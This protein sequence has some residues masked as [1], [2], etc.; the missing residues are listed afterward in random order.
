MATDSI[1]IFTTCASA[2]EAGKIAH[3]LVAKRLVAC[4]NVI[5]GVKSVFW[6]NGKIGEA[7]EVLLVL[8]TRRE[9][10]PAVKREIE[11]IHSYDVPEIIALPIAV[12]SKRYLDWIEKSVK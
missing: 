12:G 2:N 6:W 3:A 9:R 7:K 10:F 1:V 11:R 5:S 8:K 4:A